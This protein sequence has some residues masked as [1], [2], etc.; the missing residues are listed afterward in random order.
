MLQC[1]SDVLEIRLFQMVKFITVSLLLLISCYLS[2][3]VTGLKNISLS[4]FVVKFN[5]IF[6]GTP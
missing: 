1:G 3:A 6:C 4:T 5:K 2:F